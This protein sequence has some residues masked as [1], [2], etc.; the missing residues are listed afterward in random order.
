M[1]NKVYFSLPG[2]VSY[3]PLYEGI[4]WWK[5]NYPFIFRDGWE[6]EAIYD[7]PSNCVWNGGGY[8]FGSSYSVEA[9]QNIIEFYNYQLGVPLRLTFTNPTLEEKDLLDNYGNAIAKTFHNGLNEVLVSTDLM[10]NYIHENYPKY[11]I[12]RSI[13]GTKDYDYKLDDICFR[14]V[15]ARRCNNLWNKLDEIPEE[16]RDKI[17]FLCN[18]VCEPDCPHTYEHYY[19]HGV[20]QKN[21]TCSSGCIRTEI[22]RNF[23]R[24]VLYSRYNHISPDDIKKYLSKGFCHFKLSPRHSPFYAMEEITR[25]LVLPDYQEDFRVKLLESTNGF[26]AMGVW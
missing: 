4:A 22:D 16:Q 15:I 8:S 6:I 20:D 11:R 19:A 12:V 14:A 26:S 7:C 3:K 21:Y 25:Y 10:A 2:F 1:E 18:E 17:E 9:M 24:R 23:R 5:K 13:V